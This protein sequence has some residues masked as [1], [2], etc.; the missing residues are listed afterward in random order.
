M[1]SEKLNGVL[2]VE[3]LQCLKTYSLL[4]PIHN[5]YYETYSINY[6]CQPVCW[7]SSGCTQLIKH[8]YK[9]CC[10]FWEDE[11]SFTVVGDI[12]F[13]LWNTLQ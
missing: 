6:I 8:L 11:I 7:P 2:P 13:S 5:I 3:F 10:V 12:N 9:I 1:Q 4:S